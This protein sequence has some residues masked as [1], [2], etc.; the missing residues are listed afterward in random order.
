MNYAPIDQIYQIFIVVPLTGLW[1][2]GT[3]V[4]WPFN[5]S[6]NHGKTQIMSW[7]IFSPKISLAQPLTK[8]IVPEPN[9]TDTVV[10]PVTPSNN[11]AQTRF[12]ITGG[13]YS[14]DNANLFHSLTRFNLGEKQIVNFISNPNIRNILTR[15]TGGEASIINGLIQVTGGNSSLFIMNPAGIIFGANSR[16][17]VPRSFVVT[18]GLSIGFDDGWFNAVGKNN[19]NILTGNPSTFSFPMTNSGVIINEGELTVEAGESV[20]LLGGTIINTGKIS[21]PGGEITISTV[22]G[23]NFVRISQEGRLLS[24]EIPMESAEI[25][26]TNHP[27]ELQAFNYLLIPELLTGKSKNI[28]RATTIIVNDDNQI[29]LVGSNQVIPTDSGTTI[30][31][32]S[33]DISS[34]EN[35]EFSNTSRINILGEKVGLF[36]ANLNASGIYGSGNI[37]IG[38][39]FSGL[40]TVPNATRTYVDEKTKISATSSLGEGGN[41]VISSAEETIFFGKIEA[42]SYVIEESRL[43]EPNSRKNIVEVS[44]QGTLIFDGTV[45][46]GS[47]NT[48]GNLSLKSE[49]IEILDGNIALEDNP[50]TGEAQTESQI[51]KSSIETIS[52]TNIRIE[53]SDNIT[54]SD[55]SEAELNFSNVRGQIS[56]I[57]DSNQNDLGSFRIDSE[58]TINTQGAGI[59]IFGTTI[60]TNNINTKGGELNLSSSQGF[61][62]T[63]NL[64]TA[65]LNTTVETNGG[66]ININAQ[67]DVITGEISSSGESSGGNININS[68]TG[69]I[70]ITAVDIDTTSSNGRGGNVS[71]NAATDIDIENINA[72]GKQSGGNLDLRAENT[73]DLRVISTS[74]DNRETGNISLTGREINLLGG[75]NSI[76]SNG[77]LTL[78]SASENQ[79]ITLGGFENTAA[80]NLTTSDLATLANGFASI[81]IGKSENSGIITI[82]SP[83][84]SNNSGV[85]FRSPATIQ[86]ESITGTGT[87]TGTD[88]AKIT[89]NAKGDI[90][91]GNISAPGDISIT[92]IQGKI[93][94][95]DVSANI[96]ENTMGNIDIVSGGAIET[97]ELTTI[98][99]TTGG[100]INLQAGDRLKTGKINSSATPGNA[101][102]I[103]LSAENDIEVFSIR[104]EGGNIGANVEIST[105]STLKIKDSF[106]SQNQNIASIST[107][108]ELAGGDINI[109]TGKTFT[110]GD[111]TTNGSVGAIT[112]GKITVS[113]DRSLPNRFN[114]KKVENS[115]PQ[116]DNS[117]QTTTETESQTQKSQSQLDSAESSNSQ[118]DNQ[119]SL[120]TQTE[121]SNSQ[122]DNQ[123]V[124]VAQTESSNSQEDNQTSLVA[125]TESSNSQ[126]DNQTVVVTQTESSNSQEDNQTVVITQPKLVEASDNIEVEITQIP[127]EKD[128][129]PSLNTNQEVQIVSQNPEPSLPILESSEMTNSVRENINNIESSISLKEQT[130]PALLLVVE[131]Q[132]ETIIELEQTNN[133][134]LI[135]ELLENP[136]LTKI[137][138]DNNSNV[139][140]PVSN[141]L[142]DTNSSVTPSVSDQTVVIENPSLGKSLQKQTP[143][144]VVEEN[145][146]ITAPEISSH[147]FH[148]ISLT[149]TVSQI[150]LVRHR[151]Y[152]S[153]LGKNISRRIATETDIRNTLSS[154]AKIGVR[155]VIVYVSAQPNYL[156]L[157]LFLPNGKPVVTGIVK[158]RDEVI[159]VAKKFTNQIRTPSRLDSHDYLSNAQELYQWLITPI[160]E[161][162]VENN[163]NMIIFSMGRGLRTLPV[164]ALHDGQQFLVE[165]YS[166]G[167]IPNFTLT[168]TEYVGLK[169]SQIL[170]MGASEFSDQANQTPLPAVPVELKA[171]V[172]NLWP[173][174]AFLNQEFTLDNLKQERRK[175]KFRIIHLAT[176]GEFHPGGADNSYIQ[177]WDTKLSL[178][179]LRQLPLHEPQVELLVLSACTTALGDERAELGFAGLAHKAGV[180]SA[181]A[182]LWYV[183]DTGTLILMTEF[184]QH[185]SK[186]LIKAE[187]L[188]K[189]QLAMLRGDVYIQDGHILRNGNQGIP[190]PQE[191][192]RRVDK[193]LSHPYYWA[194][195]TMIGSPW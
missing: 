139:T 54:I 4:I 90:L 19:Y 74:S 87:I 95:G 112:D 88:D 188:Q 83:E 63:N 101:G 10:T 76:S 122:E 44:S 109:S 96:L 192:A 60:N 72:K 108:G 170:A 26:S 25:S 148:Q 93:K 18:T 163:I 111:V 138:E 114:L 62:M 184:Y 169:G 181:L 162:L 15:V 123:S 176:H 194:A 21:A 110:V 29:F 132:H 7:E 16:L 178:K 149:D 39:D 31:S 185:L 106:L 173:G 49:N 182:S 53:A 55:L 73:L 119:T 65:N 14:E 66:D 30:V 45:N 20:T 98:G 85:R 68:Q 167:L 150:E 124:V 97:G 52:N 57:A 58:N 159:E 50:L 92:S 144:I 12:D 135:P 47:P 61:V 80:L 160:A 143:T 117:S 118:E 40:A 145:I 156:E 71:M 35:S 186:K 64:S 125:Q 91:T 6:K 8:P 151:E 100:N 107:A 191:L 86:A 67:G 116:N 27:E 48:L 134:Q 131:D 153:Y 78:H 147:N 140:P 166:L 195:F 1:I 102:E 82:Y 94:T 146:T 46:L 133:S 9:S 79:N 193:D 70:E 172:N 75:E 168:N 84:N 121:S 22:P 89:L 33:L 187:A 105:G 115:Q 5:H 142:E 43:V 165:K 34:A 137:P 161:K 180:K 154:V 158:N 3:A 69:R 81:T 128:N 37:R 38:G 103:K 120:V 17:D 127:I 175:E 36:D 164:A 141:I 136:E 126:E 99:R 32:G 23:E 130:S 77:K 104:A 11:S 51:A 152:I 179:E 177:F 157:Q 190:L 28:E 171:I 174:K 13:K 2:F 155:P 42:I 41:I 113:P 189:A 59:S 24:L 56:F 129:E 183:S